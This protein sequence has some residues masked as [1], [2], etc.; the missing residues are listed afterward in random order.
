M[1]RPV[2]QAYDSLNRHLLSLRRRWRVTKCLR[3]LSLAVLFFLSSGLLFTLTESIFWFSPSVRTVLALVVVAGSGLVFLIYGIMPLFRQGGLEYFALAVE[4]HF[5]QFKQRLI[6]ALQ[7]WEK[8]TENRQLY[9]Q[10]MIEQTVLQADQI[11]RNID[12]HR[13]IDKKPLFKSL[14]AAVA[15]GCLWISLLLAFSPSLKQALG[16]CLSPSTSFVRPP[17]VTIQVFPGDTAVAR[18]EDLKIEIVLAGRIPPEVNL[19]SR[20]LSS[21]LKQW[22]ETTLRTNSADSDTLYCTF[23]KLRDSLAYYIRAGRSQSRLFRAKVYELPMVKEIFLQY[24]F[25]AYTRLASRVESTGHISAVV[26]TKVSFKILANIPLKKARL[27]FDHQPPLRLEVDHRVAKTELLVTEDDRY[28]VELTDT[29]GRHNRQPIHY[30]I[31]AI[32]DKSPAVRIIQPGKDTDLAQDMLLPLVVEAVDDFGFSKMALLFHQTGADSL[33]LHEEQIPI[34]STSDTRVEEHYIWDLA[35]LNLLPGDSVVYQVRVYDNDSLTGPKSALSRRLTVRFPSIE[36][37]FKESEEEQSKQIAAMEEIVEQLQTSR[38]RLE[39]LR[40]KALKNQTLSWGEKRELQTAIETQT[41][42]ATELSRISEQIDQISQQLQKRDLITLETV[43]KLEQLR[44][45]LEQTITPEMKKALEGLHKAMEQLAPQQLQ[46]LLKEFNL[47]QEELQRNIERTISVLKQLQIEQQLDAVV[48]QAEELVRRQKLLKESTASGTD[49]ERLANRQEAIKKET[50]NLKQSLE[51]LR[52]L[53]PAW[54]K[55]IDWQLEFINEKSLVPRMEQTVSLLRGGEVTEAK[56]L[57]EKSLADLNQLSASL[58]DLRKAILEHYRTEIAKQMEK[59][60]HDLLYISQRQEEAFRRPAGSP[61]ELW[62]TEMGQTEQQLQEGASVVAQSLH[63]VAK[64]TLWVNNEILNCLSSAIEEMEGA[65]SALEA[66][67]LY[68]LNFRQK[69]ALGALNRTAI[70]LY[71]SLSALSQSPSATGFS[72]L[73]QQLQQL[74]QQQQQLNQDTQQFEGKRGLS[75][76]EQALLASLAAQQI[77][78]Q[79]AIEELGRRLA[80]RRDILGRI[81]QLGQEMEKVARDL[82]RQQVTSQTLERQRRILRRLLDA[83]RSLRKADHSRKRE[84]Q[85]GQ[86]L[87]RPRS[88]ALPP[89]LGE[90]ENLLRYELQKALKQ[91]YPEEYEELLMK[92]FEAISGELPGLPR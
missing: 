58:K 22:S 16:R 47:S 13:V 69:E 61:L 41:R 4:N 38:K 87:T 45:L 80:A 17:E 9:S 42:I 8:R 85:V 1:E 92:Y 49:T 43:R 28:Y 46:Q 24:Q 48:K 34:S 70:L 65:I 62:L 44:Q 55:Q 73:L 26:G 81:D 7:L 3:G 68:L 84:S 32:P 19:F 56:Q 60:L 54:Q 20:R 66:R 86:D 77:A 11:A 18:G 23:D 78:L 52:R 75:S 33:S 15:I 27:V 79:K 12:L 40:R 50:E 88:I 37:I 59:A 35:H 67:N 14:E 82:Q 6:G 64:K 91:G 2:E 72:Q 83:Q 10:E 90:R 63:Q 5:S 30:R 57:E 21:P 36:E 53:S 71:Q 31:E 39:E 25:P 89:S 29:S 74:S 76:Q 51:R